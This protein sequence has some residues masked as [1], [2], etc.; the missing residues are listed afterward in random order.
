LL[1]GRKSKSLRSQRATRPLLSRRYL[2]SSST[3]VWCCYCCCFHLVAIHIGASEHGECAIIVKTWGKVKCFGLFIYHRGVSLH[4]IYKP[5][6]QTPRLLFFLLPP[7]GS[8]IFFY[9]TDASQKAG[10]G[11]YIGPRVAR[12]GG[13]LFGRHIRVACTVCTVHYSTVHFPMNGGPLS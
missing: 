7:R 2:E 9:R 6:S 3:V 13:F 5:A 1:Q 12:R 11:M 8:S 4:G 10:F